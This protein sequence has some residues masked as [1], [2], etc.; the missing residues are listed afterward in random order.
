[1]L[2]FFMFH[3]LFLFFWLVV[4]H[5]RP[6]SVFRGHT[7]KGLILIR[8]FIRRIHL[9][10]F[11]IVLCAYTLDWRPK[12][13]PGHSCRNHPFNFAA[14]SSKSRMM[15]DQRFLPRIATTLSWA[16]R[17]AGSILAKAARPFFG[18][19]KF[20]V[21]AANRRPLPA[22]GHPAAKDE[23]FRNR[24]VRSM[25]SHSLNSAMPHPFF[26]PVRHPGS[27]FC[28]GRR[29]VSA[30]LC[31]KK[32]RLSPVRSGATLKHAQFFHRRQI[33]RFSS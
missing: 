31:V 12:R 6:A 24:V 19:L 29:P 7:V 17:H 20:H 2:S 14:T 8:V 4:F 23:D 33:Q 11:L 15:D 16:E 10:P 5:F 22:P 25:P 13:F 28:V 1:M 27:A 18:N 32:L 9:R 30:H 26:W 3:V 21:T